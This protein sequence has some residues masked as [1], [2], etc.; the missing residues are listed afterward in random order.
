MFL[1]S[2]SLNTTVI[3]HQQHQAQSILTIKRRM[4]ALGTVAAIV[5]VN[6][7]YII[8]NQ[9]YLLLYPCLEKRAALLIIPPVN[10]HKQNYQIIVVHCIHSCLCLKFTVFLWFTSANSL[11]NFIFSS[12]N[13]S[14]RKKYIQQIDSSSLSSYA[15]YYKSKSWLVC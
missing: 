15:H 7:L 12:W 11:L 13:F 6:K 4:V 1:W 8:R 2:I 5:L 9:I 3:K 10:I 14:T